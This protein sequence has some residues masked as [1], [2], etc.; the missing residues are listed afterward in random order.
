MSAIYDPR[1]VHPA[2]IGPTVPGLQSKGDH[3]AARRVDRLGCGVL[4]LEAVPRLGGSPEVVHTVIQYAGLNE[5]SWEKQLDE[6]GQSLLVRVLARASN[7]DSYDCE[8]I[9]STFRR[10]P[11]AYAEANELVT[12]M[13]QTFRGPN[14][15]WLWDSLALLI[16]VT[17]PVQL[18]PEEFLEEVWFD[19]FQL[20]KKLFESS[21]SW[22]LEAVDLSTNDRV[23][24]KVARNSQAK[25]ALLAEAT[26]YSI[27]RSRFTTPLPECRYYAMKTL[28][29]A[30][31]G[32]KADRS[33]LVSAPLGVPISKLKL[34]KAGRLE[35][36]KQ[37]CASVL[38]LHKRGIIHGDV[39]PENMIRVEGSAGSQ[40]MLI[41]Y[42]CSTGVQNRLG[43]ARGG[44]SAYSDTPTSEGFT[45]YLEDYV[46]LG[47]SIIAL[48]IG[49]EKF[50]SLSTE[51]RGEK[52]KDS[53]DL[54][55]LAPI[56]IALFQDKAAG[57]ECLRAH[58]QSQ[59]RVKTIST[60]RDLLRLCYEHRS[61]FKKVMDGV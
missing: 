8:D 46:G 43:C 1:C 19:R 25:T 59:G 24:V 33:I 27:A 47:Y 40:Y 11:K 54:P 15:E 56:L 31:S 32:E 12:S 53:F 51:D 20:K 39:K 44:T 5:G 58:Q 38:E 29:S 55:E 13:E 14:R 37:I 26:F 7:I 61:H 22:V 16:K 52:I 42:G 2:S 10:N 3:P 57:R 48:N 45:P 36:F 9:F 50:G 4:L 18:E 49:M 17:I 34:D 60:M 28:Q 35:C 23:A 30:K 21:N 41:D 6:A